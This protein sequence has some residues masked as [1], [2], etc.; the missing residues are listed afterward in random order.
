LSNRKEGLFSV[1]EFGS[2]EFGIAGLRQSTGRRLWTNLN[3]AKSLRKKP[4]HSQ[5]PI[6][7][8]QAQAAT[9]NSA[10]EIRRHDHAYYVGRPANS[11]PTTNTQ[12]FR[13]YQDWKNNS[14]ISSRRSRPPKRSRAR[15][16]K[17]SP[18]STPCA[19]LSL[20]QNRQPAIIRQ[21]WEPAATNQPCAERENTGGTSR[22]R[23]HHPQSILGRD[24]GRI[25]SRT[26]GGRG[27][28]IGVHYVT[29]SSRWASRAAMA[30]K[31]RHH[32]QSQNRPP[33]FRW[34]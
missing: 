27:V 20:G 7:N 29:A 10:G 26:E 1:G 19:M 18:A 16:A 4:K 30:L 3:S 17:S 14:P 28:S 34:N 24:R 15:P 21:G 31:R 5:C 25:T 6:I 32:R 13:N 2:N 8:N 9:L 11:S 22:V 23:C 12:L 33:A